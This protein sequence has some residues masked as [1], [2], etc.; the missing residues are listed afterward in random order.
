MKTLEKVLFPTVVKTS[1]KTCLLLYLFLV[2]S[3]TNLEFDFTFSTISYA[4]F[5]VK[6]KGIL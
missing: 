4:R 6:I 1:D 5:V 2:V 3:F